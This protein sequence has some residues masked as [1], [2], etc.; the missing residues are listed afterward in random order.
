MIDL[1]SYEMSSSEKRI[2]YLALA[3]FAVFVSLVFYRN[4]FFAAVIIPFTGRIKAYVIE[5]LIERRKRAFLVQFK[6]ELFVLSTAIGAG[7]SMKDAIGES[8]EGLKAIHGENCILAQQLESAYE[9]M[10]RG[11][12]NDVA[13]LNELGIASGME[14]VVDFVAVYS[15]CKKTGAS[16]ILAINKATGVIIDKM[17]IDNEIREIA[18]RKESECM[19]ILAM[20]VLIIMFLN[21]CS[22]EYISPLYTTFTGRMLMTAAI[23]GNVGIYGL[24]KRITR[25]EI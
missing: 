15:I 8:I 19:V 11:G 23:A 16:L 7:R 22:P 12:E 24:I 21:L 9:R 3:T 6:D 1:N 5:E 20:P 10:E 18:K 25:I 17:S 13:V 2:F 4:I 14:D